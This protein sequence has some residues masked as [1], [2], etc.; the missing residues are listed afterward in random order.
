MLLLG[1][2]K[3]LKSNDTL[4]YNVIVIDKALYLFLTLLLLNISSFGI[5]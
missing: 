1:F 2:L 3:Y 4:Y 5:K